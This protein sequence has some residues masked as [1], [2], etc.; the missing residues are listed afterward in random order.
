MIKLWKS[1]CWLIEHVLK[2]FKSTVLKR[3]YYAIN[4]GCA[5]QILNSFGPHLTLLMDVLSRA[6]ALLRA[7][8]LRHPLVRWWHF[9]SVY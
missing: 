9:S 6:C 5:Q 8:A 7:H 3:V 4:K 1:M 2:V